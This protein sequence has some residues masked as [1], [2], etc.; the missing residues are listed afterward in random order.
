VANAKDAS[1]LRSFERIV[2]QRYEE[3]LYDLCRNE[4]EHRER[5]IEQQKGFFGFGA[6]WDKV[7][8]IQTE[9]LPNCEKLSA[10]QL[11]QKTQKR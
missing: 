3:H 6:D 10:L 7:R 8:Q 11:K 1:Q 2:E 9:K 5:R 4:F